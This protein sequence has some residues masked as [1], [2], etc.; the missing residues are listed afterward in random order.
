MYDCEFRWT[1]DG[2]EWSALRCYA[3]APKKGNTVSVVET[4]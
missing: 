3:L 2:D 4:P 1:L